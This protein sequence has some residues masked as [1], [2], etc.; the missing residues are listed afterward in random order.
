MAPLGVRVLTVNSGAV[1]SNLGLNS[2][3]F[4]LPAKSWYRSIEGTIAMR[5]RT[6]GAAGSGME[7][8]AYADQ[9]LRDVLSNAEGM[10][11]RGAWATLLR[12]FLLL[13]PRHLMVSLTF[14]EKSLLSRQQ[15]TRKKDVIVS[16]ESGLDTI[17][18][19]SNKAK[20]Y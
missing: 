9:F 19:K 7:T 18:D 12:C 5:A 3:E 4:K 1:Q 2:P 11:W 6:S 10:V 17:Y 16:N 8:A 13:L 14:S 20:Q 15:L